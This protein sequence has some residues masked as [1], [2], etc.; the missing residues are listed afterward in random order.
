MLAG[1]QRTDRKG[2]KLQQEVQSGGEV[3]VQGLRQAGDRAGGEKGVD[4]HTHLWRPGS[5]KLLIG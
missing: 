4:S 2:T 5:W 3:V 1:L